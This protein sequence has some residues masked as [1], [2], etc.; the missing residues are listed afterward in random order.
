MEAGRQNA[1]VRFSGNTT[2]LHGLGLVL[3]SLTQQT[4]SAVVSQL[5]H[6]AG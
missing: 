1:S 6:K 4:P 2:C 3:E 5:P